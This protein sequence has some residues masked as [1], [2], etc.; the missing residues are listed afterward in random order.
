MVPWL[1][2]KKFAWLEIHHV[3]NLGSI[4]CFV[5]VGREGEYNSVNMLSMTLRMLS[6]SHIHIPGVPEPSI[7]QMVGV[8]LDDR[9]FTK[10]PWK[11]WLFK[12][13][14]SLYMTKNIHIHIYLPN[15]R[16]WYPQQQWS[17]FFFKVDIN[18]DL[19]FALPVLIFN[20]TWSKHC[21]KVHGIASKYQSI[22]SKYT[23]TLSKYTK[24]SCREQK[25][26][27]KVQKN[28]SKYE[29]ILS[30][31]K[32][33]LQRTKAYFPSTKKILSEYKSILSEYKS[34]FQS[35]KVYL[36]SKKVC[37]Q[38]TKVYFPTT[39]VWFQSTK[40]YFP[41]TK[42]YFQN[43]K[44]YF[45]SRSTNLDLPDVFFFAAGFSH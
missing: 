31:Y 29:S 18:Y 15:K 34:I 28:T 22:L 13:T 41:T 21:G 24:I 1:A 45:C 4:G 10:H 40:V 12:G 42:A 17:L 6:I 19:F 43:T 23:S 20:A 35:T 38:S 27:F 36:P 16:R 8:Q 44:V 30:K 2:F 32:S 14:R 9:S 3:S 26:T 37:F 39:K 7:F 25:Y 5:W 11:N 33:T